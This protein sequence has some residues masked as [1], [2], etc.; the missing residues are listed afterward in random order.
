MLTGDFL[1]ELIDRME[2][3]PCGT[4]KTI[5]KP[6]LVTTNG[7]QATLRS[8][9]EFPILI[10]VA[11]EEGAP[12]QAHID[13]KNFGLTMQAVPFLLGDGKVRL[14]LETELSE[15][16]FSNPTTVQGSVIPGL[17]TRRSRTDVEVRFGDTVAITC[18]TCAKGDEEQSLLVLVTARQVEPAVAEAEHD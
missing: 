18:S 7:R 1:E 10:P 15:R 3:H 4:L 2:H 8:G 9:G 13:W 11:A 14:S 17:T 6:C 12:D 16:D 5:A